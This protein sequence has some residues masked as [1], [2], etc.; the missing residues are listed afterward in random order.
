VNSNNHKILNFSQFITERKKD[1]VNPAY[2]TKDAAKMKSEIKKNAK[3]DDDDPSAYVSHP[4]GGWQADYSK[5]G[6]RYKT[7]QSKYTKAFHKK[8]GTK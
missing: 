7:S 1:T 6:K 4:D 2:L 8:Y 5:S 3:K